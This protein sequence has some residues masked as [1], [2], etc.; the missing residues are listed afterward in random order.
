ME[1][2]GSKEI[3][4][5]APEVVVAI[6]AEP[7]PHNSNPEADRNESEGHAEAFAAN[8]S[9]GAWRFWSAIK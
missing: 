5:Q 7:K 9:S 3:A 4:L 2:R 1:A 6:G 8:A